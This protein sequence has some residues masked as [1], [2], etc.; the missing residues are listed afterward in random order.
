[1]SEL[2]EIA[3]KIGLAALLAG[4]VGAE[5]ERTGQWA[6]L[7]T[8]MLIAVGATLLTHISTTLGAIYH[9]GSNAWDPSRM[10][11]EIVSGIGFL[12]AGTIIQS[13]GAVRGLT[14]AAGIWVAAAIGIGVGAG[15]FA[16]AALTS[17]ALLL[18]LAGLRPVEDRFLRRNR[19]VMHL[20]LPRGEKLS[21][22]V[23]VLEEGRIDTENVSVT[24][25]GE[26]LSV[27]VRFRG[28]EQDAQ[29]LLRLAAG[30]EISASSGE[31]GN[32]DSGRPP[33]WL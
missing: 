31:E 32:G 33:G 24:R 15:F 3:I 7:R 17:V 12:G 6:G 21:R 18:I 25:D 9:G 8:H 28:S 30:A 11:A 14:T 20:Q 4:I 2:E 10:A 23:N 19:Q 5:R 16:E 22:L 29:R 27:E 1:M 26:A 13:R